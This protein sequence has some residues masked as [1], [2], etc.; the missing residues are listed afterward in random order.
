MVTF[1]L[2]LCLLTIKVPKY[3]TKRGWNVVTVCANCYGVSNLRWSRFLMEK[4]LGRGGYI[5]IILSGKCVDAVSVALQ[6]GDWPVA[7]CGWWGQPANVLRKEK[8]LLCILFW[9]QAQ[10]FY[11]CGLHTPWLS[12]L[13]I[14][15]DL[16]EEKIM[17]YGY[18]LLL[19]CIY[20]FFFVLFFFLILRQYSHRGLKFFNPPLY[21]LET[22]RWHLISQDQ[23]KYYNPYIYHCTIWELL[24]NELTPLSIFWMMMLIKRIQG[25]DFSSF[26]SLLW[27]CVCVRERV[28]QRVWV[29]CLHIKC[30]LF[31]FNKRESDGL[32][33]VDG[34]A[35]FHSDW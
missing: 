11:I 28:W 1:M 5:L 16:G 4:K 34:F 6:C 32:S 17:I 12:L 18:F 13:P 33:S 9:L 30:K 10:V 3:K 2:S 31:I 19:F 27:Q 35:Q 7:I 22:S 29:C 15:L 21:I 8:N 20:I 14:K 26:C 25:W 24:N 23:T